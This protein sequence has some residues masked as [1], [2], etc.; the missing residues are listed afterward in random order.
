MSQSHSLRLAVFFTLCFVLYA[1]IVTHGSFEFFV[2]EL[3]SAAYDS[4]AR[5]LIR[6]AANVSV[7][8]I[9]DEAH[10][11]G[12]KV[13]M[14][15]GLFPALLRIVLNACMPEY[16]G[17]WGRCSCLVAAMLAVAA[18]ADLLHIV[19]PPALWERH[20]KRTALV[21]WT[22]LAAIA[23]A[24]P[25]IFLLSTAYI[26]HEAIL[27]GLAGSLVALAGFF[28]I[29]RADAPCG[30]RAI[31]K[32][33]VG[34]ACALHARLTF[35]I[36]FLVAGALILLGIATRA[37]VRHRVVK[38]FNPNIPR[39]LLLIVPLVSAFGLQAWYNVERYDSLLSPG[40]QAA[41]GHQYLS[42]PITQ[43][44]VFNLDRIRVAVPVYFADPRA[45][46]DTH[47]PY[48]HLRQVTVP[49]GNLYPA[50]REWTVSLFLVCPWLLLLAAPGLYGLF[51]S[52]DRLR[53]SM[54]L[55]FGVQALCILSY[56]FIT[57]RY[58]ADLFPFLLMGALCFLPILVVSQRPA[59]TVFCVTVVS[60]VVLSVP[61]NLLATLSWNLHQNWGLSPEESRRLQSRFHS[62]VPRLS[63]AIE[64]R[65]G[66]HRLPVRRE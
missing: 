29:T 43:E 23:F 42:T 20:P 11:V 58:V 5:S 19:L 52:G 51:R 48:V 31:V 64:Y 36:P 14:Y 33:S 37:S 61:A 45:F 50:Y 7:H 8:H 10:V 32:L 1:A 28:E 63:T 12:G 38:C 49:K 66:Q 40:T 65:R 35:G 16:Y 26:Y 4:L 54:C 3:K 22:V 57:Q 15:F 44:G 18:S 24:S 41:L 30:K 46:I 47:F 9:V 55:G 6:G 25:I 27:W 62:S 56:F 21:F 39:F 13:V 2:F 59:A 60:L 34:A 53:Q 17:L